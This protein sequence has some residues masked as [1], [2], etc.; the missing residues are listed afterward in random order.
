M[1][2]FIWAASYCCRYL[3]GLRAEG[4]LSVFYTAPLYSTMHQQSTVT[5]VAPLVKLWHIHIDD[6]SKIHLAALI[7]VT[8]MVDLL[9]AISYPAHWL[10]FAASLYIWTYLMWRLGGHA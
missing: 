10:M 2:F 3:F 9:T 7:V 5:H 8:M 6:L 4:L 1:A